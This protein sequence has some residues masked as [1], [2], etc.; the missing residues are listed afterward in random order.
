M[1]YKVFFCVPTGRAEFFVQRFYDKATCAAKPGDYCRA[2]VQAWAGP[3]KE[4][5]ANNRWPAD[6]DP[7][8]PKCCEACGKEFAADASRSTGSRTIVARADTGEEIDLCNAPVGACWDAS[9]YRDERAGPDGRRLI[10]KTPGGDW[11]ID[12]RASNCTMPNDDAHRCWVRH[13]RPED[14]TLNVDKN[15][16]TCQAGAGSII[17]GN[18][19]GFLRNGYLT[20]GC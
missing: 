16:N 6:T 18:Y 1:P 10:V 15:G 4:L 17:C 7:R 5:E 8:W 11:D 20:D 3:D 9:W 19:H 13:G 12:S 14:G 2:R